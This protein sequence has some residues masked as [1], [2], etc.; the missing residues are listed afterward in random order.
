VRTASRVCSGDSC[1][2]QKGQPSGTLAGEDEAAQHAHAADSF[3]AFGS[4]RAADLPAVR[5]LICQGG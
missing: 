2:E 5:R 4:S 3:I 1:H